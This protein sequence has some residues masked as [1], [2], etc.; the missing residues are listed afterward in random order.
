MHN[1]PYMIQNQPKYEWNN[2]YYQ[3]INHAFPMHSYNYGQYPNYPYPYNMNNT[4]NQY[5]SR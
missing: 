3:P 2:P 5:G 4:N 1:N